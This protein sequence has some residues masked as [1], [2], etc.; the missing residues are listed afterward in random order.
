MKQKDKFLW[1][2]RAV[3]IIIASLA[4]YLIDDTSVFFGVILLTLFQYLNTEIGEQYRNWEKEEYTL[5]KFIDDNDVNVDILS[6][7]ELSSVISQYLDWR[8]K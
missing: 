6:P 5:Q 4:S 7:S 2:G 3:L 8:L 1:M